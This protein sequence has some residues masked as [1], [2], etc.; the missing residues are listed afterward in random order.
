MAGSKTPNVSI[1]GMTKAL[2]FVLIC[3]GFAAAGYLSGRKLPAQGRTVSSSQ[4]RP[5]LRGVFEPLTAIQY[6]AMDAETIRTVTL[7]PGDA[8]FR[9]L[10]SLIDQCPILESDAKTVAVSRL[11]PVLAPGVTLLQQVSQSGPTVIVA[12][13]DPYFVCVKRSDGE[14]ENYVSGINL[15]EALRML[16]PPAHDSPQVDLESP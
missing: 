1:S 12:V 5:T 8:R 15:R 16:E 2:A 6:Q 4:P 14:E 11:K 7:A 10:L 9:G 3:V 13:K